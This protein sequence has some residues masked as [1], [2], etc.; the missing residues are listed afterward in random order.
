MRK[1]NKSDVDGKGMVVSVSNHK[2]GYRFHFEKG[3][4][5]AYGSLIILV[6]ELG[7]LGVTISNY[8]FLDI[9]NAL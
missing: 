5:V 9:K 6:Y 2:S 4:L 7:L 8:A 1:I 3:E